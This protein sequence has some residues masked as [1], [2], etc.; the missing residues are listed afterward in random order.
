MR[1]LDTVLRHIGIYKSEIGID[2]YN[3]CKDLIQEYAR[4]FAQQALKDAAENSETDSH[5]FI[6]KESILNAKIELP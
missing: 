4:N 2:K 1:K 6:D 5:G 3:L